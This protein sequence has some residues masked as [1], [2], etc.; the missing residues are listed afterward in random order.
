MSVPT[1]HKDHD[2]QSSRVTTRIRYHLSAERVMSTL[3]TGG[4]PTAAM[5]AERD[6]QASLTVLISPF[7]SGLRPCP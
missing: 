2:R 1:A 6:V 7:R 3:E 5:Y 4:P